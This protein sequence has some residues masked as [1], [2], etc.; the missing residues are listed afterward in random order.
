MIKDLYDEPNDVKWKAESIMSA[1][2]VC[3]YC[4]ALV[5]SEKGMPITEQGDYSTRPQKG[6]YGVYVCTN[7]HMPTFLYEDIQVPGSRFGAPV[8]NVPDN[9]NSIYEEARSSYAA[10]AYTGVVLLCRTL[11]MHVGVDFGA[12]TGKSFQYYVT[13]LKE[14]GYV[15]IRSNEWV[16]EI[17]KYGNTSTHEIKINTKVEAQ[18]ILQFCEMLL[19]MNYEYPS[20]VKHEQN[21]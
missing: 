8:K 21:D 9:V 2:Y 19:K 12:D 1:K 5:S 13:Y 18:T 4:G 11:L 6:N 17:R 7:C 10:N 14:K 15:S 20:I 16:D 3:G